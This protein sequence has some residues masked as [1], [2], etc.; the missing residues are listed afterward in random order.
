MLRTMVHLWGRP[1]RA[2]L[3]TAAPGVV[4]IMIERSELVL[5]TGDPRFAALLA[6]AINTVIEAAETEALVGQLVAKADQA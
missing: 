3:V 2:D 6:T 5:C 1:S 4:S